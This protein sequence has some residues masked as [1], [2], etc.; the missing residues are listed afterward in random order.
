MT[1]TVCRIDGCGAVA[2]VLRTY[3]LDGSPIGVLMAKLRCLNGH[4]YDVKD[5]G[6]E[7]E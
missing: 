1:L 2:E 6:D 4:I 5:W 3:W 7:V